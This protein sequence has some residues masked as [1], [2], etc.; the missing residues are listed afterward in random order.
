MAAHDLRPEHEVQ[1]DAVWAFFHSLFGDPVEWT[2]PYVDIL[3][4]RFQFTKFMMLELL[5]AGLILLIYVPLARAIRNGNLPRGRF[6][7]MFEG[8]LTFIRDE[9]A[10]PNLDTE[11][12]G[13]D[14]G[15][16]GE[17]HAHGEVP[18]DQP[19][20]AHGHGHGP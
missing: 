3:G 13:H 16:H 12:H 9:I 6:W 4:Y 15:D 11:D 19:G 14:H 18:S 5:A 10:R 17:V 2:L 20:H 8:M 1:D 7:N